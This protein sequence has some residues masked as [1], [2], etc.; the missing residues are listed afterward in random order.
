MT[1]ENLVCEAYRL[2]GDLEDVVS[3]SRRIGYGAT[4]EQASTLEDMQ[5]HLVR[6]KAALGRM[7]ATTP[8]HRGGRDEAVSEPM[9]TQTAALADIG[10][11]LSDVRTALRRIQG[12]LQG[13][14]SGKAE[15]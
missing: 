11:G 14:A 9:D 3:S 6:I 1:V 5:H 15:Q 4:N 7:E 12:T 13:D 8:L 2:L 10:H